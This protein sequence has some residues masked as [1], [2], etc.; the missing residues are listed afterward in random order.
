METRLSRNDKKTLKQNWDLMKERGERLNFKFDLDISSGCYA[1]F[2]TVGMSVYK[3]RNKRWYQK[4][5]NGWKE[6]SFEQFVA[7]FNQ[8]E[9]EEIT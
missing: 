3:Y 7:K 8:E 4:T 6:L 2:G 1:E 9:W 5:I